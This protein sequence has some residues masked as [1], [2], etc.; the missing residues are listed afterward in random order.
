MGWLLIR[1]FKRGED[2][3]YARS[4]I[5]ASGKKKKFQFGQ[6]DRIHSQKQAPEKTRH[7][8]RGLPLE[9]IDLNSKLSSRIN[10][11]IYFL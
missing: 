5:G 10:L 8:D 6:V 2:R 3:V 1:E 11:N 7:F 9:Y 4:A